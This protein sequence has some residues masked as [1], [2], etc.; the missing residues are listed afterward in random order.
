M[1]GIESMTLALLVSG[2]MLLSGCGQKQSDIANEAEGADLDAQVYMSRSGAATA[3][4][5]YSMARMFMAQGKL[6]HAD[7][8]L[9][10]ATNRFPRFLPAY[11]ELAASLVR[12]NRFGPAAE[13]LIEGLASA[14]EDP[15]MLN[16]LGMCY[17]LNEAFVL[18]AEHFARAAAA[19]PENRR[20]QSNLALAKG[21]QG[22]YEQSLQI[23][24]R[25]LGPQ[26]AHYNLALI[27]QARGDHERAAT[28]FEKADPMIADASDR[29]DDTGR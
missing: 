8:V 5:L 1:R 18:A 27:C 12:Q 15:V 17:M 7:A 6:A 3:R 14:P 26:R 29:I 10:A 13:V 28:E 4:E 23:Y 21:M 20:Y 16:D 19:S 25:V 2:S 24:T 22:N 9:T 11:T